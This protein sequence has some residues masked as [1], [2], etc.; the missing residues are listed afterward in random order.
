MGQLVLSRREG[1]RIFI[2]DD[3]KITVLQI[4]G[5]TVR[6]GLDCP[7]DLPIHREEVWLR[8]QEEKGNPDIGGN[9]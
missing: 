9:K 7:R 2:G 8:I 4:K 5:N 6:I 1:E 3:I